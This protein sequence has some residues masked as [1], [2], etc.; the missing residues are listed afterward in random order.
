MKTNDNEIKIEE[1]SNGEFFIG[2]PDTNY[3]LPKSYN[4]EPKED[5]TAYELAECLKYFFGSTYG[6]ESEPETIKR[7]FKEVD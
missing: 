5:I 3:V 2:L 6:L 4:F 1:L 7:H